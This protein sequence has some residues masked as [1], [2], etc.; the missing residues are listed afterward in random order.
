MSND[1]KPIDIM[2]FLDELF[3][4]FDMIIDELPSLWKVETIGDSFMVAGGLGKK[5]FLCGFAL[6][7]R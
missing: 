4:S 6:C 3:L 7:V 2:K 1:C 5:S